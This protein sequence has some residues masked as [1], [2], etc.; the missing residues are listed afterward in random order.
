MPVKEI[1]VERPLN[2]FFNNTLP[3]PLPS[4]H[5]DYDARKAVWYLQDH[6][7]MGCVPGW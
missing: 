7:P 3:S 6:S 1:Q 4:C 2:F 5:H